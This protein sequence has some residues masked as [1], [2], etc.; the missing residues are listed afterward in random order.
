[1]VNGAE[2]NLAGYS[3]VADMKKDGSYII[4]T[5]YAGATSTQTGTWD[6]SGNKE[7]LIMTPA[8]GSTAYTSTILR[9]KSNELWTKELVGNDTE[10][11]HYV[12]N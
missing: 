11:A 8:G 3:Y 2:Q 9:L 12:S 1:M 5:S 4:T 10:E 6:F 7:S